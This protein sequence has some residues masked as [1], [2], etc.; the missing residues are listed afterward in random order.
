MDANHPGGTPLS[1][2]FRE[3]LKARIYCN[4]HNYYPSDRGYLLRQDWDFGPVDRQVLGLIGVWKDPHDRVWDWES[5]VT[6][7]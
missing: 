1:P 7:K 5:A 6:G 3:Y 2:A 4:V